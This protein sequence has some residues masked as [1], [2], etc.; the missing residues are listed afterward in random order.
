VSESISLPWDEMTEIFGRAIQYMHWLIL[1]HRIFAA[2]IPHYYLLRVLQ[3]QKQQIIF[4][5][6]GS[7]I[8]FKKIWYTD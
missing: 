6:Q 1:A 2:K 8:N 4:G 7:E 3:G 5:W